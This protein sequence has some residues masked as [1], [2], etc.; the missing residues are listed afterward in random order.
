MTTTTRRASRM[1]FASLF[2]L[3]TLTAC[4]SGPGLSSPTPSAA[5]DIF[6]GSVNVGTSSYQPG[7]A[8]LT[9]SSNINEGFDVDLYRWLG[10]HVP[11]LFTPVP[12]YLTVKERDGA[13]KEGGGAK[14]VVETYSI[15]D[16][17]RKSVGFAGPYML[18]RQGVMV[19]AGDR[20]IQTIDDLAGK[21]V[22]TLAGSTSEKQ[23]KEGP[24]ESRIITTTE[25]GYKEC[26]D[27]LF[28]EQRQVDAISTDEII[29]QGFVRNDPTK[30]SVVQGL[31]FG[32]QERYGV[33]LPHG[34]IA[35]CRIMTAKLKEFITS[36]TWDIF[37]DQ[38]FRGLPHKEYKPDPDKLD[39]CD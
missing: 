33:G 1:L 25:A 19:R 30:L 23:I 34:D 29:L 7:F 35:A 12:V 5:S 28:G 2:A 22:C 10:S 32:A 18:S 3:T 13:L 31:T 39:P 11:P 36:G 27:R 8:V 9:P 15:T 26:I 14:F 6:R 37:F 17:R 4:E 24:L 16:E 20:R 38:H 21:T